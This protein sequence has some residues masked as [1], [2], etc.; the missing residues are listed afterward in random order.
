MFNKT[1]GMYALLT[2]IYL[3]TGLALAQSH[4]RREMSAKSLASAHAAET[5]KPAIFTGEAKPMG[6]GTARSWVA[7]DKD[8]KPTAI[9]VTFTEAALGGLPQSLTP[10]LIWTEFLLSLP[11]EASATG[12]DHIGLNWNPKGHDPEGVYQTPHFDF[13]F[14]L[15]S[16]AERERITTRGDDLEKCRKALPVE[17]VPEGY[18]PA[19]GSEEPGMGLHWVEPNSHEFHGKA[20]THTF[21]YGSY[22]G[23]LIFL[24][25]MITKAFLETRPDITVPIKLSSKYQ[26]PGY[27]PARYSVKYHPETGEY[28]VAMEGLT[29]R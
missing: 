8:G 10:G 4:E 20:F 18:V 23:R 26:K 9:G 29:L 1:F 3:L 27:Y 21:I 28:S 5:S 6:N 7:L 12:F 19:A 14:Y 17:F 24:E 15:I 11:P 25:P 13:H 16:P 22:D 2:T